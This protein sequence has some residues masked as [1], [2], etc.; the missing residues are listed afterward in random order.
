[1]YQLGGMKGLGA[2]DGK[3]RSCDLWMHLP[4]DIPAT[5]VSMVFSK[6]SILRRYLGRFVK[7]I[8][9]KSAWDLEGI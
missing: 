2:E 4:V 8:P 7:M 5:E 1:M 6:P 3:L 9:N